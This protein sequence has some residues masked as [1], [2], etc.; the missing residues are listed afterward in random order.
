MIAC[1]VDINWIL[2]NKAQDSMFLRD[3]VYL[4]K[5]ISL[6]IQEKLHKARENLQPCFF[7]RILVYLVIYDSR[8]VSLEHFLL[9]RHLS[10]E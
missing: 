9:S 8:K 6:G 3:A 1:Q 7:L 5:P 10:H 2:L 4:G